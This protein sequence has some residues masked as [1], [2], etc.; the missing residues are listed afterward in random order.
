MFKI[1]GVD[2]RTYSVSKSSHV[3][4]KRNTSVF[5]RDEFI[6]DS[7]YKKIIA[8]ALKNGLTSFRHKGP[9]VVSF[10]DYK[11][12]KFSLLLFLDRFDLVDDI[13][14]VTVFKGSVDF[15]FYN[16]FIRV[17]N[18]IWI[19]PEKFTLPYMGKEERDKQKRTRETFLNEMG[20]WNEDAVFKKFA[21]RAR[22]NKI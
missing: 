15:P 16:H 22:I 18:R 7:S 6:S 2:D 12:R 10:Q 1:L 19:S 11:K 9:V 5:H 21:K 17:Q 4:D 13:F 8:I 14:V 3:Y 20:C